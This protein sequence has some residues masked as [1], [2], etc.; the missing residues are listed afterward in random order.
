MTGY[1]NN[2]RPRVE[3][4]MWGQC[5]GARV[6]VLLVSLLLVACGGGGGPAGDDVDASPDIDVTAPFI[7]DRQPAPGAIDVPVTAVVTVTFSEPMN[8]DTLTIDVASTAALPGAVAYDA[9]TRALTFTPDAALA[10]NTS[11]TVTVGASCADLAGNRLPAGA[12]TYSFITGAAAD[13][14]P[15]SSP[16]SLVATPVSATQIDLSWE[17]STDDLGVVGYRL[18][19]DGSATPLTTVPATSTS[20]SG[21]SAATQFCYQVSAVDAAGN[22]SAPSAE[23]CATTEAIP[24]T[25]PPTV[26]GGLVA[27]AVSDIQIVLS[28]NAA[29]DDVGVVGYR[30]FRGGTA[31]IPT[32]L[33]ETSAS[34]GPF[35]SLTANTAY[36]YAVSARDA[37][38]NESAPSEEVCATTMRRGGVRAWGWNVAGQLGT[39]DTDDRSVPVP[40]M[41]LFTSSPAGAVAI[42]AGDSHSVALKSDGSVWAWGDNLNGQLGDGTTTNSLVPTR[43]LYLSEATAV[44]AGADFTIALRA[45]GTVWAWGNNH[46]G[47]LGDGGASASSPAP[48]QVLEP[49][50]FALGDVVAVAAGEFHGIAVKSDGTVWTWGSNYYGQLGVLGY[51]TSSI[52]IQA[53]GIADVTAV[54]AGASHTL[55]LVSDGTVWAWGRNSGGQ[56]GDGTGLQSFLPVQV[57]GYGGVDYL[58]SVTAVAAGDG[59][60]MALASDGTIWTWGANL[61]G[62]LGDGTSSNRSTPVHVM[63]APGTA[64]LAGVVAIEGGREHSIALMSD[65]TVMAWGR[66]YYGQLGDGNTLTQSLLPL[67]ATGL[68]GATAV[69]AGRAHTL[70]IVPED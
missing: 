61:Y 21:L 29:T 38:G 31:I 48:V 63:D 43:V 69:A 7:T 10:L 34:D 55:A 2:G 70:A 30:V 14:V 53:S 6:Q 60:S 24:D 65:G 5:R 19:R 18:Y 4:A 11:Y 20:D 44:A 1:M 57:L 56:L 33:T 23:T 68:T 46:F 47:Q 67:Q 15:P 17:A 13:T 42:A 37:A 62:Q 32:M 16:T 52:A 25:T 3:R 45:D 9:A 22:E 8:P 66:N 36:C 12:D 28:W 58:A 35:T 40:V 41:G 26:P 51:T 59:H 49:G 39:M 27:E 64:L 50:G 54:A